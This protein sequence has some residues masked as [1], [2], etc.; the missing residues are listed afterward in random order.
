MR[1][2]SAFCGQRQ[3]LFAAEPSTVRFDD[4][5]E[6]ERVGVAIAADGIRRKLHWP[7]NREVKRIGR[8]GIDVEVI[9]ERPA[10]LP[11]RLA[12]VGELQPAAHAEQVGDTDP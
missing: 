5:T 9:R 8:A 1:S 4:V 6:R 12:L 11:R 2:K 7:R 10:P 3:I